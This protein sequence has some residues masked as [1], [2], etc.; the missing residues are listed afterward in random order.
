M[1]WRARTN[2]D[3]DGGTGSGAQPVAVGREGQ[4]LNVVTGI[5]GVEVLA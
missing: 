3:L 5:E 1:L 2:P 4:G